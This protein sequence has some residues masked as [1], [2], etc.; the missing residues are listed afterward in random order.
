MDRKKLFK[1]LAYLIF[2][3]FIVTFTANKFYWY[4]SIPYLDMIMHFLCG[5]WVGLAFTY[6]FPFK[7]EEKFAKFALKTLLFVLLIGVGWEVFE[8]LV[9][10]VLARNP[11]DF[12]DTFSDLFF[13]LFGG[14][15]AI[16]YLWKKLPH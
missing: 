13:D 8:I 15:C 1:T 10:D 11:F 14:L 4:Y 3:I 5:F 9:N 16:L 6:L 7:A 12:P 2:L